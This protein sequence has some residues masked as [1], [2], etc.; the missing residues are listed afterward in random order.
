MTPSLQT[1]PTIVID[2]K[3]LREVRAE[4]APRLRMI[5]ALLVVLN[6]AEGALS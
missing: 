1:K 5:A 6:N 3:A 2:E 4:T